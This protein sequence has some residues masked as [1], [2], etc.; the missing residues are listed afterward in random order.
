MSNKPS[1]SFFRFVGWL[2]LAAIGLLLWLALSHGT[3]P[4]A[5]ELADKP[6]RLTVLTWNTARMG[7][8][9]KPSKN[10]VLQFLLEQD[11]DVICLPEVDVYKVSRFLTLPEVKNA[12]GA[13]YRYSYIDFSVYNKWHQFGTMVWSKYPLIHKQSI[14]YETRGNLSNRC[15][16]VVGS[17]TIRLFNNHLESYSFER[18]DFQEAE[19]LR[20]YEGVRS[21]ARNLEEKWK[22]ARPLRREQARIIH[23]EIK[24]SPYPVIVVGDFNSTPI[25]YT[26]QTIR[27]GL[28][29]AWAETSWGR[30]GTTCKKGLL[31]VHIDYIL[32]SPTIV[33]VSCTIRRDATGSDHWPVVATLAW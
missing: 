28:H 27:C 15:D 29:D 5:E 21:S 7:N 19:T 16:L 9:E 12:L 3:P 26:Y 14:H 31:G 11:A 1:H 24:A 13:K 17:D 6:H 4:T 30:W 32:S 8:F 10:K 2:M 25:S 20:N 33:P 18:Q 22:R 23:K